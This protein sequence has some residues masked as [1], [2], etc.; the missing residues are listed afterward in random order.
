MKLKY[1]KLQFSFIYDILKPSQMI[2]YNFIIMNK[3]SK[4]KIVH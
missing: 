3:I 1:I 2:K 4:K